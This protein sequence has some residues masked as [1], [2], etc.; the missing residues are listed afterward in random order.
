M[1]VVLDAC[2]ITSLLENGPGAGTVEGILRHAGDEG[3]PC[4]MSVL[5]W[6]EVFYHAVR[7][8]GRAEAELTM[9]RLSAMPI[10]LV[11]ADLALARDAALLKARGGLSYADC[12][13]AAL[14]KRE[15]AELVT[16]DREFKAVEKEIRIRWI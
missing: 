14:A 9:D 13:A 3:K 8:S 6:G 4:F 1:A 2:A 11:D 12:F 16:G 10:R 5:N 7:L 15:G